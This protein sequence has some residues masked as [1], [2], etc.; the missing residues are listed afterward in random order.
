[1][2]EKE[3]ASVQMYKSMN[4]IRKLSKREHQDKMI[5][6]TDQFKALQGAVA[7]VLRHMGSYTKMQ[8]QS[9]EPC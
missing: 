3:R 6:S 5:P 7:T 4:T 9:H 1:M 2:P 8:G